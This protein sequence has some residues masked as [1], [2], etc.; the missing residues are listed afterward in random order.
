MILRERFDHDHAG[1]EDRTLERQALR[2]TYKQKAVAEP[3]ERPN[4]LIT[5]SLNRGNSDSTL[6]NTSS[7]PR[8]SCEN[9]C[10]NVTPKLSANAPLFARKCMRS[11]NESFEK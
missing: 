8:K 1:E 11:A 7:W 9:I 2:Q 10:A 5:R 6:L 4:K 3:C